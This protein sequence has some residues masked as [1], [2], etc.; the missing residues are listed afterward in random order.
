MHLT[1]AD[2]RLT[3]HERDG[4]RRAVSRA[5]GQLHAG[6]RRITLFG[7][8]ADPAR[9]R[10]DIDLLIELD[11]RQAVDEYLLMQ[12]LRLALEDELGEQRIDLVLDS[13]AQNNGFECLA[14]Q[15][16]VELWS[17]T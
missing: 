13:G 7:S 2:V 17:N 6:W 3:P 16:G 1:A 10:G 12:R 8:R 9:R 14:R 5:C 4:I 11:P 15:Q